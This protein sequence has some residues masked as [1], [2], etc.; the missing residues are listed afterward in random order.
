MI[1]RTREKFLEGDATHIHMYMM[2]ISY[3]NGNKTDQK[4]DSY[5]IHES[6]RMF[7]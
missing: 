2:Q 1:I 6:Q 5:E 3:T 4:G 7:N